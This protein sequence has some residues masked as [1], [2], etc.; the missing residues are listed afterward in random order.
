[1][2]VLG[3]GKTAEAIKE[4]Y[5]E[6]ELFDDA[7]KDI[8]DINSDQLTIVS[9][10]IPPR[11]YLVENTKNK[12]SDYD[13]FLQPSTFNL[14]PF[15]IWISG[16]N[17]KTTTTSMIYH[18]LKD[19]G[20]LYGGNI[21]IPL[22]KLTKKLQTS[23][24]PL[25]P[26]ILETS[27]FTLHYTNKVKP[28]IYILLPISEDHI[29]WHGSFEEYRDSKLKP[30]TMM[31]KGDIAIVPYKY[32]NIKS[33]ATL[34]YYKDTSDIAEQFSIDIDKISFKEPFLQDAVLALATQKLFTNNLDYNNI[35]KFL[36]DPHKLE[37]FYDN[38]KNL[39]IDD[40][41]ATNI[42]ATINALRTY[43][44]KKI[45]LILG[46]D[47]KGA[48]LDPLFEEFKLYEIELYLIGKN[49]NKL[50]KLSKLYSINSKECYSMK[51]AVDEIRKSLNTVNSTVSILSPA[52]ASLDQYRS[53]M[54]RG[55]EFKRF[56]N[57]HYN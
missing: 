20:A 30:L 24:L 37:E 54:H 11:N 40:S 34:Y 44:D 2:R 8:Y 53:Y 45:N 46:G 12:I 9:P 31:E 50:S 16:T 18:L 52:A 4:V 17:G 6:A 3:K 38:D 42:D 21:G 25:Q 56:V 36:Q 22:A 43:K 27:S 15:T 32:R 28:N 35:N 29:S 26:L 47:D 7:D 55:E 13:L 5:P 51:N 39:W 19:K 57:L 49:T 33:D 10:G 1:M 14:Q 41:K 23:T 48:N